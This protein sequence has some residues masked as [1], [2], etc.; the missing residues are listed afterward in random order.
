MND[1]NGADHGFKIHLVYNAK[2]G[3]SARDHSTMNEAPELEELTYDFTTTKIPVTG[4]KPTAHLIID[5]TKIAEEDIAKFQTLL[6][7]LYGKDGIAGDPGDP[8]A[9]PPIPA[10]E[11]VPAILP[12]L[13][14][15]DEVAAIFAA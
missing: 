8:E 1:T 7:T 14:T 15:P 13:L 12:T 9:E 3:V 10:V 11:A 6:D 2:A 5:S 4:G